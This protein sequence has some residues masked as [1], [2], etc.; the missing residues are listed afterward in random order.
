MYFLTYFI[1][2]FLVLFGLTVAAA[3][4]VADILRER[5]GRPRRSDAERS[6]RPP[7]TGTPSMQHSPSR[8]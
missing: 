4:L 6:D 5:W 7:D 2:A 1:L 8:P 3:L